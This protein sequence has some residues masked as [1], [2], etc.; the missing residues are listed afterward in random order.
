MKSTLFGIGA[1]L[2][3]LVVTFCCTASDKPMQYFPFPVLTSVG[4]AILAGAAII[5]EAIERRDRDK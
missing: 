5:A 2:Q 3:V 4:F 1:A